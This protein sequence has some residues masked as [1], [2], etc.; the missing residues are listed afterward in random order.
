M[1][2]LLG[3]STINDIINEINNIN[4]KNNDLLHLV[5]S[6]LSYC[7]VSLHIVKSKKNDYD[8]IGSLK[9]FATPSFPNG[10]IQ[11]GSYIKVSENPLTYKKLEVES[12]G[13]FFQAGPILNNKKIAI[14]IGRS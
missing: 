7:I 13:D 2:L 9:E 12:E 6:T 8:E 1:A 11:S 3:D 4:I 10:Y 14:Y 5:T